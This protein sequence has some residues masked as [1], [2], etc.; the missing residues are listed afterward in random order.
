M[1]SGLVARLQADPKISRY[2]PKI[3]FVLSSGA[4]KGFCHVGMLEALEARGIR[5]DLVVGTSAG[6]LIGALYSHFG[7]TSGLVGRIEE[8]VA[9]DEFAT[10]EKRYF[11]E[12]AP[13]DG[14]VPHG[15]RHFFSSLADSVRMKM[16]VGLSLFTSSMVAK[17]DVS[18]LYEKMFE[19]V[20]GATLRFPFAAVA[21]DL[22]DGTPATFSYLGGPENAVTLPLA[23]M[24]SCAIPLVFPAVS[25]GGHAFADGSI[26]ASLPIREAC[27]L[28]PGET[29]FLVA[30]DVQPPVPQFEEKLS[31][32][33]LTLRLLDLATRSKQ[34]AD[35]ELADVV[36]MPL[37]V[38]YPWSAFG[39]YKNL[40]EL[41]KAYMTDERLDDFEVCFAE[42]CLEKSGKDVH[43]V[44]AAVASAKIRRI[45]RSNSRPRG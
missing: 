38:N 39:D 31:S 35:R 33:D 19:G 6:S 40:I 12:R 10:F 21:V 16:H 41:G 27:A 29:L 2:L 1:T 9:S 44:R 25:M 4:A 11:G 24:A 32:L 43:V 14:Q 45:M 15:V 8:V 37:E 3:V 42:K 7:A 5:P 36:F 13:L 26:M 20:S 28:L 23:V 18:E 22:S 34:Y 17:N 30:F